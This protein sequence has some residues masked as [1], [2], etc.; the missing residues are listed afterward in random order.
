VTTWVE[1]KKENLQR[2]PYPYLDC[3]LFHTDDSRYVLY[4]KLEVDENLKVTGHSFV[5]RAGGNR[6]ILDPYFGSAVFPEVAANLALEAGEEGTPIQPGEFHL[7]G[8]TWKG[9]PA[10]VVRLYLDGKLAGEHPYDERYNDN[11]SQPRSI[12]IGMRPPGWAGE[13]VEEEDGTVYDSR[14]AS[15]MSIEEGGLEMHDTRLYSRALSET[16]LFDLYH[17]GPNPSEK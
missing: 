15:N 1:F 4:L 5:A 7:L 11:R 10:G 13:I 3:V 16:E 12:A 14:P 9:Q 17:A 2:E 6:R 8:M